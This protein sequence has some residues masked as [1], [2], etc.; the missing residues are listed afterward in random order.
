[1]LNDCYSFKC[2]SE[3]KDILTLVFEDLTDAKGGNDWGESCELR[4]FDVWTMWT[5][6]E[7]EV[8]RSNDL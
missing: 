7:R 2:F 5:W 1:M 6:F 8:L 3:V 4:N